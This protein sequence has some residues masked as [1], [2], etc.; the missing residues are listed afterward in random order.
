MHNENKI[1]EI[2]IAIKILTQRVNN[3]DAD[4]KSAYD[5]SSYCEMIESLEHE[6]NFLQGSI[7]SLTSW[8]KKLEDIDND[9][10][11]C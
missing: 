9:L 6:K 1:K 4:I 10:P 8:K 7:I 2:D 3:I 11:F 5:F